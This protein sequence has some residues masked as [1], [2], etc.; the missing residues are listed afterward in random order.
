MGHPHQL[1][2]IALFIEIDC[3]KDGEV[4]NLDLHEGCTSAAPLMDTVQMRQHWV[5]LGLILDSL[6]E[7]LIS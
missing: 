6:V 1:H 4:I 3:N 7:D 5:I 2:S